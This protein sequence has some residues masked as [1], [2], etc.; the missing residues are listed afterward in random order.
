VTE[1]QPAD[2]VPI[3]ALVQFTQALRFESHDP[4]TNRHRYYVLSWQ[5]RLDGSMVL[6]GTWGRM[7]THGRS[8]MLCTADQP[9]A[10]EIVA[11]IIRRRLQRGYHVAAW[12]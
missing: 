1:H 8:R 3:E 5:P 7:Q 9:N 2:A 11:R 12:H 10:Q 6:V 4:A